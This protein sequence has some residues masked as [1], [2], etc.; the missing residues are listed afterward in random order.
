VIAIKAIPPVLD[1]HIATGDQKQHIY[2]MYRFTDPE[3]FQNDLLAKFS[4][5]GKFDPYGYTFLYRSASRWVDPLL[6][7]KLLPMALAAISVL[8]M[9]L[10]AR[11]LGGERA[12]YAAGILFTVELYIIG[13]EKHFQSGVPRSFAFPLFLGFLYYWAGRRQILAGLMLVLEAL[14]YPPILLNSAGAF[15][16]SMVRR[17]LP[18][19]LK[20]SAILVGGFVVAASIILLSYDSAPQFLG[21]IITRKE[22]LS[23]PEFGP[24]GRTDFFRDN[25]IMYLFMGRAC[26]NL[27]KVAPYIALLVPIVATLGWRKAFRR[28]RL[29][30]D[31]II[32]SLILFLLAHAVLF[33]LHLPSRYVLYSMPVAFNLLVS[34]N[35]G[36]F[37][38][39][40]V[41]RLKSPRM[42]LPSVGTLIVGIMVASSVCLAYKL[43]TTKPDP[44]VVELTR[45]L[46]TLPKDVLIAGHPSD[47]DDVPLF[48]K[49]KV[50][51][52]EE[53]SLPYYDGYYGEI[54]KR[55]FDLFSAYYA[56]DPEDIIDFCKR[57]GVDYMVVNSRYFDKETARGKIYYAPFDEH[58][59]RVI[60]RSKGF[61][62]NEVDDSL[63][64]YSHSRY[65]VI[66][67]DEHTL[68]IQTPKQNT[69]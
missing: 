68:T 66:K 37:L 48:S 45:F 29:I 38:D 23:M 67:C 59:K 12:G 2:W 4:S 14:F 6:F 15:G 56:G 11:M 57:Y 62:L 47:M 36:E 26:L 31:I 24:E 34:L 50:L 8:Y 19:C 9:F 44:Q 58:A 1:S 18:R 27:D 65:S 60:R 10:L 22:A 42:R 25:P 21:H 43:K 53:L 54:R 40:V 28:E 69:H 55:T 39:T 20:K 51:V 13:W 46:G 5:S 16:I 41:E 32:S 33:K 64:L 63:K 7:S 3:L 35:I 17:D 52:N 49:R 30:Y 61:L